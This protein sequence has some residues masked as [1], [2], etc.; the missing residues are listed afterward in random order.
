MNQKVKIGVFGAYRGMTMINVLLRHPDAELVAI[1]DKY[2]PALQKAENAAKEAGLNIALYENFEDFFRHDMDAVV[3]AN[4]A[5][6][7]APFAVRL[8]KSGRHVL[9]EVLP[10]ETMAQAVE[11]IEAAESSGKVYAYA[12]NY[13]YMWHTFEMRARY[14]RGDIGQVM[15]A[16]GEYVHDCSAIWPSITYG[17]KDHWRNNLYPTF[18]CTHSIGPMLTITGRRPVQV[19]G[20]V[21]QR[22]ETVRPLGI[23]SGECAGIEILTL[24]NGAICKSVHGHLKREPGSVNYEIYGTKGSMESERFMPGYAKEG[25]QPELQVYREGEKLCIGKTERYVPGLQP[26]AAEMAQ[27]FTTHGGSDF[28]P[29]HFF[30]ERILGRPDGEKYSID[31]Y[32]AVDMGICGI[33]AYRSAL[34]GNQP[35]RV[36]NLRN[37]EE[38]DA[39]RNDNFCTNPA[40]AGKGQLLP[41]YPG[42][43][44]EYP[45]SVYEE[46]RNIWL[47]GKNAE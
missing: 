8:L 30:I 26:I 23:K 9:S 43:S 11:L 33:L 20:F 41:C 3:L 40:V 24:D 29:T 1:C 38:R 19:T 6:E 37:R 18:Y 42:G 4:Y 2:V 13:C 14:E 7:H 36:P 27:K 46:V 22:N 5:N 16:E 15:Y 44:L 47:S 34:N 31:V 17:E 45:D 12:E 39:W 10:C 28:Y 21:T 25:Q 35:M 32:S